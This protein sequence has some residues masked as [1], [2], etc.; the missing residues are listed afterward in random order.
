MLT[1][2]P[3]E[4]R[5]YDLF[6]AFHDIDR[7][8]FGSPCV[9]ANA[10]RTDVRDLGN[11]FVLDAELPGFKKED[12]AIQIENNCLTISAA[13]TEESETKEENGTYLRKE[14]T[15]G[16]FS[17]SFGLENIDAD[18]ITAAYKDGILTLTMP[19]QEPVKPAARR[20]EIQDA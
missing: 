6:R 14:R 16:S 9:T 18:G 2:T 8:F 13:R 17:R 11:A 10:F 12:I 20:L 3:F 4:K 7:D 15:C 5:S 19:K 1:L